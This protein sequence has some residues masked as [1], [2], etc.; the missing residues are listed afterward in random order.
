MRGCAAGEHRAV[1]ADAERLVREQPLREDRWAIL[2][3]A[4]YQAGR[5]AE[6]L[7]TL[8]AARE[9]LLD[10]LGIE[11]GARLDEL[12]TAILRQDPALAPR[13]PARAASVRSAPTAVS[14]PSDPTTPTPSSAATPTSRR[15]SRALLPGSRRHDRRPVR[16]GKVLAGARRRGA[17]PSRARPTRR[18]DATRR[19]ERRRRCGGSSQADAARRCA[20]HRSGR[21]AARVEPERARRVLRSG[22]GVPHARRHRD[23]HDPLR[24]PRSAAALPAVGRRSAAASTCS[25]R[26]RLRRC[27]TRSSSRPRTRGPAARARPRRA[28]A[29]RCRRS[30]HDPP[31][32]LARAAGDLGAARR[33]DAHRRRVRGRRRHRGRDRAVRRSSYTSRLDQHD[34]E[35]CRSMMLRLIERGED[36]ASVRRRAA[37]APLLGRMRTVDV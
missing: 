22:R 21:R 37:A 13:H 23:P 35:L 11:P 1:I 2:A 10:E 14:P 5:Q 33:R 17:A 24:L 9:R 27:A 20:R 32:A 16:F 19:G 34:R 8:R 31:A 15:C 30:V 3:L 7:A 28:G 26:S 36:G 12:E 25:A 29:S 6:A 4:N 18:G